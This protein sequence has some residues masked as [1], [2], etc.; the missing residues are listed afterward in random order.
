MQGQGANMAVEDGEAFRLFLQSWVNADQ[1]PTIL[2]KIDD[3]RRLRVA[4]VL[5]NTREASFGLK[6][7]ERFARMLENAH[8]EGIM[9]L[10]MDTTS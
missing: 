9:A 1:V 3:I 5:K 4:K 6:A 10:N 8:Y 7:E 2:S